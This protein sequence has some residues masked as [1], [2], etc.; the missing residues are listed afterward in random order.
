MVVFAEFG[1]DSIDSSLSFSA[2]EAHA[3]DL[4]G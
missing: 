3:V 2:Y 4:T 1:I